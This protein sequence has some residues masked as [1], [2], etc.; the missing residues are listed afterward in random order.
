MK[1][2][3]WDFLTLSFHVAIQHVVK[4]KSMTWL[5][6]CIG[7][8]HRICD[9]TWRG[10]VFEEN[11]R[12]GTP[13]VQALQ[14]GQGV[15]WKLASLEWKMHHSLVV[16]SIALRDSFFAIQKSPLHIW[17]VDAERMHCPSRWNWSDCALEHLERSSIWGK[18]HRQQLTR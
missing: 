16:Y 13:L 17:K 3:G 12:E 14:F 11:Q 8:N 4:I 15:W 2:W 1:D 5:R 9:S 7:A 6:I 18:K 10:C